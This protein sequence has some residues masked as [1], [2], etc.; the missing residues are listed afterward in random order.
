M[1][2]VSVEAAPELLAALAQSIAYI[3]NVAQNARDM[4]LYQ[5]EAELRG[6]VFE[7]TMLELKLRRADVLRLAGGGIWA[8]ALSPW[9]H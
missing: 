2:R 5:R 4:R 9:T 8:H 6:H 1:S 3:T 7:L